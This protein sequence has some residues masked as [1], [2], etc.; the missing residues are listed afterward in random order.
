MVNS[1]EQHIVIDNVVIFN[2]EIINKK[3]T[4][5]DQYI[6]SH[7]VSKHTF[8]PAWTEMLCKW[9]M[10]IHEV[11]YFPRNIFAFR[12]YFLIFQKYSRKNN[13]IDCEWHASVSPFYT[14][15]FLVTRILGNKHDQTVSPPCNV[16]LLVMW[17]KYLGFEYFVLLWRIRIRWVWK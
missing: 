17:L 7:C 14:N 13:A 3:H 11:K 8:T 12:M 2:H 9:T 5:Q 4:Y 15:W 16:P 10:T 1:W 6:R